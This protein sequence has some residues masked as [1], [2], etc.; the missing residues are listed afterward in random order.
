MDTFR[1]REGAK[2]CVRLLL[3]NMPGF[4][5][6]WAYIETRYSV[7]KK[8]V[9]A[10]AV[11]HSQIKTRFLFFWSLGSV[12]ASYESM[13]VLSLYQIC[14]NYIKEH[15]EDITSLEGVPFYP[16]VEA[17]L[18]HVLKSGISLHPRILSVI[19]D[20]HSKELRDADLPWTYVY[21][22]GLIRPAVPSLKVISRHFPRFIT[23]LCSDASILCDDD[24]RLLSSM[25]NLKRLFLTESTRITDR[26]VAYIANI[27]TAPSPG[28]MP[29]LEDLQLTRLPYVTDKSLKYIGQI[30]SLTYIDISATDII[31]E[32]ALKYLPTKGFNRVP[33]RL[34][35]T[36]AE[37]SDTECKSDAIALKNFRYFIT[38]L[39]RAYDDERRT[40][41][42]P[43]VDFNNACRQTILCFSRLVTPNDTEKKRSAG[44]IPGNNRKKLTIRNQ[45]PTNDFLTVF[46]NEM[47]SDDD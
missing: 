12:R 21:L 5:T 40:S 45:K 32:V 47:A 23:C 1:L 24:I 3:L 44:L 17:L 30:N 15:T 42:F 29:F 31:E 10:D 8:I 7:K 9:R 37:R 28:G 22:K 39:A 6:P 13:P 36:K 19:A 33:K 25:S 34:Y 4:G 16:T 27:A 38:T 35:P 46:E 18:E 14:F 41:L 2:L 43:R 26:G 11:G 20:S